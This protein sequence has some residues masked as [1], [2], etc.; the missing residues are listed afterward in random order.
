M[1]NV[2]DHT[3]AATGHKPTTSA[4][5]VGVCPLYST[6]RYCNSMSPRDGSDWDATAYEDDHS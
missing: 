4:P 1:L 2:T 3:A 5:P 6:D